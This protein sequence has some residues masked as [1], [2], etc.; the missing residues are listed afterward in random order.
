MIVCAPA[1]APAGIVPGA[2][3]K[4]PLVSAVGVARVVAGLSK[5]IVTCWLA[6]QHVPENVTA[7]PAFPLVGLTASVGVHGGAVTVK[8]AVADL[9]PCVAVIVWAPEAA[10]A[11]MV[12]AAPE[13]LPLP[14]AVGFASWVFGL[15]KVIDTA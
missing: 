13:K 11:G 6:V 14:S 5:R 7:V 10:V 9:E 3:E 1:A 2:P 8:F 15:S 12:P 4:F